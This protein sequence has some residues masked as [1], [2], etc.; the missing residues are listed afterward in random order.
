VPTVWLKEQNLI[1]TKDKANIESADKVNL[2]NAIDQRK[3]IASELG[4]EDGYIWEPSKISTYH[5]AAN[6]CCA[7][8][9]MKRKSILSLRGARQQWGLQM[10]ILLAD[11]LRSSF[12]S[13]EEACF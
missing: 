1:G 2:R 3:T 13:V 7:I 10:G 4:E 5:S 11:L 8:S 12:W 9:T 6:Q